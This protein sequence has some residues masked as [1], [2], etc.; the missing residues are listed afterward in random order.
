MKK[1]GTI[2]TCKTKSFF[3]YSFEYQKMILEITPQDLWTEFVFRRKYGFEE[4]FEF[5]QPNTT[6]GMRKA[7][8]AVVAY[9]KY[10]PKIGDVVRLT[11][12]S[13][14]FKWEKWMDNSLP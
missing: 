7:T 4:A 3:W 2:F 8:V 10:I 5:I 6:I 12:S 14:E 13:L 1:R 9:Y 11:G